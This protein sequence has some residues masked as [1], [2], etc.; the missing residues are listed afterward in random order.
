MMTLIAL[1]VTLIPIL[2]LI[3]L[4]IRQERIRKERLLNESLKAL[5]IISISRG[6]HIK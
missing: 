6:R 2:G 1:S 3:M 5:R 4:G